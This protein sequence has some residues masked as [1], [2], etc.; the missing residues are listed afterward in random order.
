MFIDSHSHLYDKKFEADLDRVLDRATAAGVDRMIVLGDNIEN[1]RRAIALAQSDGRVL[2]FVGVHPHHASDWK[3]GDDELVRTLSDEARVVGIGEIGLDYHYHRDTRDVQRRVF[4]RQ[5]A[6]ARE[7]GLPV[8]MHCRESYEDLIEDLRAE[9]AA[10]IGGVV[11]CFSGSLADARAI[12]ELGLYLG[13]GGTST[14]PSSAGLRDVLRETGIDWILLETDAPYLSPHA[15]RGRRNEPSHVPLVARSL[16][17]LFGMTYRDIARTTRYNTLRAFRLQREL[18]PQAVAVYNN[19]LYINLTNECTNACDFCHRCGD[20]VV[21]GV[22][23]KFCEEPPGLEMILE[24]VRGTEFETYREVVISGLGEPTL[25]L[26]CLKQVAAAMKA[27]GRTV[28]LETNGQG[29]LYRGACVVEE[30]SGLVDAVRVS[31]N[32]HDR[33]SYNDICHPENPEEAFDAVVDFIRSA[34][35]RFPELVATVVD[36]PEVNLAAV[37][38]LAESELGVPLVVRPLERVAR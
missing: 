29:T 36:L 2:A 22:N 23:L 34:R 33:K 5:L 28:I 8:S 31:L 6:L 21:R 9:R 4:R 3:E 18:E 11:H 14:Y 30:L 35:G 12:T 13:V 26:E 17:E 15:K 32:G 38:K 7:T 27:D 19:Q 16:A 25:R 1:S 20:G 37:R 24:R 10:E